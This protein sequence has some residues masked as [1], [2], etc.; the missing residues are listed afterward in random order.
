MG[1]AGTPARL[2]S[3]E[4]NLQYQSRGGSLGQHDRIGNVARCASMP[5]LLTKDSLG[6]LKVHWV[7]WRLIRRS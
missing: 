5:D 2:S 3:A 6:K 1:G 4:Q 7:T